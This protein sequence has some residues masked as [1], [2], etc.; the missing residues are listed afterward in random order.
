MP[1]Q[2]VPPVK[3]TVGVLLQ[4]YLVAPSL[5]LSLLSRFISQNLDT[6]DTTVITI[7]TEKH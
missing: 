2:L 7:T 3:L 4:L 5:S 1:E 6:I